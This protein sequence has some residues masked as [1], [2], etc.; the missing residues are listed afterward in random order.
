MTFPARLFNTLL[1][2]KTLLHGQLQSRC[3][4][5]G[6]EPAAMRHNDRDLGQFFTPRPVV[7]FA[8][9]CLADLGAEIRGASVVDPACG[10][11][12]WLAAALDRGAVNAVGVD[13]D[14]TL[15]GAWDAAGLS[16][17]PQCS[18]SVADGLLTEAPE[19]AS[20]DCVLGNPP[21]GT[22]LH[23]T[24]EE[25]LRS[26]AERYHHFGPSESPTAVRLRR[27]ATYPTELL[28]LERFISLCRPGGWIAIVLPEGALSNARWRSLRR[29]LLAQVTAHVIVALPRTAF[30]SQATSA[31]T[32]LLVMQRTVPAPASQVVLAEA[33][34]C[35]PE[36]LAAVLAAISSEDAPSVEAPEGLLPPPLQR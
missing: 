30:R 31:R 18:M 20:F 36:A 15:T 16:G 9:D 7:D 13:C 23:A 26:I 34:A 22:G 4:G 12:E 29:N 28:F 14:P 33:D 1:A 27:L 24:D 32:C 3:R 11:G 35:T 10:P 21:F 2:A 5:I 8:L 6:R 19:E 25:T 17:M